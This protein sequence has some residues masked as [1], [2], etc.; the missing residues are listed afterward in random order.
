MKPSYFFGLQEINGSHFSR[1]LAAIATLTAVCGESTGGIS[2]T[3]TVLV[4][5]SSSSFS[6]QIRFR[7]PVSNAPSGNKMV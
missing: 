3:V 2:K 1:A 7:I 6:L 5:L 4:C